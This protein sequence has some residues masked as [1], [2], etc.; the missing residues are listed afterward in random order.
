VVVGHSAGGQL[1]LWSAARLRLPVGAPGAGPLVVPS[2]VVS[3]AG[4]CDLVAG[5]RAGIGEG[6]VAAFLGAG[7]DEAPERYRLASPLARL[8][9]GIRQV[10][11]HGDADRRVP[12]EQSRAY[13]AAASAAGDSVDLVE[14][15]DV[16]HMT[17]IDPSSS[18]WSEVADRLG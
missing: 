6:A 15:A 9:L 14:L 13:A 10:L 1:A 17:P 18:A 3:L 12:V 5:A 4:V 2:L 11:L 16:D 8:P 7:P